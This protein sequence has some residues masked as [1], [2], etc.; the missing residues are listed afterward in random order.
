MVQVCRRRAARSFTRMESCLA[1]DVETSL[2]RRRAPRQPASNTSRQ[3]HKQ[4]QL[5]AVEAS[6]S[7]PA[8]KEKNERLGT[9]GFAGYL[10]E[11]DSNSGYSNNGLVEVAGEHSA[12]GGAVNNQGVTSFV[13]VPAGP[14]GEFGGE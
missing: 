1:L 3:S 8:F 14:V 4:P 2:P 7:M 12:V 10:D 11:W 5:S 6:F 9:G 13:F